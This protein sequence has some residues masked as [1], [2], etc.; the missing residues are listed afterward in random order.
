MIKTTEMML[1]ELKEYSN[2]AARLSR[3]AKQGECFPIVRGLYETDRTVPGYLL[4]GCIYGPS[5]I[6]FEYA[7]AYYGLIPETVYTITCATFEKKKK[8][9]YKTMFGTF[10]YRD[11]PSEAFPLELR[12][13]QEKEYFYRIAEPEKALCDKLYTMHPVANGR[14]LFA[15]L[16]E[17]LR[18]E[19]TELCKLDADKV[20][21]LAEHYHSGNVKKMASLLRRMKR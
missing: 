17:D 3:M 8:K 2:P 1:E 6:S 9:R 13:V 7:L 15:L 18:I 10:I 20:S 11:V 4:A 5:Y 21:A 19:E 16:T 14:E 12:V